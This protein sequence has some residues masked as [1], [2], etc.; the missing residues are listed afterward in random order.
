[1]LDL[2]ATY[3]PA[4]CFPAK[5]G[6]YAHCP[7]CWQSECGQ[8]SFDFHELFFTQS[9]RKVKCLDR[10]HFTLSGAEYSNIDLAFGGGATRVKRY[11]NL[12]EH[13]FKTHERGW[14]N[15]TLT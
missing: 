8:K 12:I 4:G 3:F 6:P 1:M 9:A 15:P 13:T 2:P 14:G 10:V 11:N 7:S 5:D